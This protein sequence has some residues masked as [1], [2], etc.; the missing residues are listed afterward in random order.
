MNRKQIQ[1]NLA[2]AEVSLVPAAELAARKTRLCPLLFAAAGFILGILISGAVILPAYF[3]LFLFSAL[4][5]L[6]F[7]LRKRGAGFGWFAA[8]LFIASSLF[9]LQRAACFRSFPENHIN[10]L[11]TEK[12][13]AQVKAEFVNNPSIN[14]QGDFAFCT[15]NLL[16][17][18]SAAGE[19]RDIKGRSNCYISI[20][21]S[22]DKLPK[23]GDKAF[24]YAVF[25]PISKAKN[26]GQFD[27]A[28]YLR[29][30]GIQTSCNVRSDGIEILQRGRPSLFDSLER[31]AVRTVMSR[32][33]SQA[34]GLLSALLIGRRENISEKTYQNFRTTGLM[35]LL[36]LSGMHIGILAGI[37]WLL[38]S[39]TG[40]GARWKSVITAAFLIIYMIVIPYRS[41]AMRATLICLLYLSAIALG[42]RANALNMLSLA[43]LVTLGLR[44]LEL[45][46]AGWQLSFAS[47]LSIIIFTKPCNLLLNKLTGFRFAGASI[48]MP[49]SKRIASW[50]IKALSVGLAVFAGTFPV[51]WLHFY[52]VY[53]Y[54]ALN[55]ILLSPLLALNLA[56]GLISAI[57]SA[58][59]PALDFTLSISRQLT[60]AFAEIVQKLSLLP[61]SELVFGS[62][63]KY[64]VGA[65]YP[66]LG[67]AAF[68][69]YRSGRKWKFAAGGAGLLAAAVFLFPIA[70]R[71][72]EK[73]LRLTALSVGAGQAIMLEMPEGETAML[74]CGSSTYSRPGKK[75]VQPFLKYSGKTSLD[76]ICL[77]HND[78]DHYSGVDYLY[79]NINVGRIYSADII[80]CKA[81][82][83][84]VPQSCRS[85][86]CRILFWQNK[87]AAGDNNRSIV[88]IIQYAGKT[89][90]VTGDVEQESQQWLL[91]KLKAEKLSP[92]YLILPHHGL[93]T[94]LDLSFPEKLSPEACVASCGELQDFRGVYESDDFP[95]YKTAQTGAVQIEITSSGETR[96]QTFCQ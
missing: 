49:A 27:Y 89:I 68:S 6:S 15:L 36:S 82:L 94:T 41:P 1:A 51:I 63:P 42:R 66:A 64:A 39:L 9:G 13:L 84:K 75:I 81:Q 93:L 71:A 2:L 4:L 8:I 5:A 57:V 79:E 20:V 33:E 28:G 56:F 52:A 25:K 69:L 86:G 55:T 14:E 31:I 48:E 11:I 45:Y 83:E 7:L 78:S 40:L 10:S 60:G 30:K 72:I 38:V 73:P 3:L 91:E 65:Y 47:V 46:S 62:P 34:S 16:S 26:P 95:V 70:E 77:S 58:I 44:P 54:S 53:P 29:S 61:G 50:F 19:F 87:A 37:V 76:F 85:G 67:L 59:I 23:A 74:D 17:I 35:H 88:Q 22:R 18:E 12:T 80:S 32:E 24:M 43:C 96:I 92:D 21:N 90:A